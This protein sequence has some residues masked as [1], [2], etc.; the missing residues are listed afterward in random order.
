[1]P[2]DAGTQLG[3]YEILSPIGAGGMGEVYKARDTRLDRT[4]AIKVLPEHVASD[5]DLKQRFEREAKTISSLNHPHICTLYDIGSQDGVDFLVMEYLEG[6]TLAQRLEKGALPLDQALTVAIEIADAL[7]K[8]HRQGITHR[9]LKPGNI[10]LTKAGAKLLDFGLAKLKQA[11]GVPAEFSA[12][13]TQSAGLTAIGTILG[14]LQHMAPEQLAG[15]EADARSDIF[16]LGTVIYEM[17]TGRKAFEG[18]S[19]ATLAGAILHVEPSSMSSIQPMASPALDHLV[20]TCLAKDQDNRWQSAGDLGRQLQMIREGGSQVG[21]PVVT[22]APQAAGWRQALPWMLAALAVGSVITG[23]AVWTATR[24]GPPI[25]RPVARTTL[26]VPPEEPLGLNF[27]NTDVAISPDGTHVVYAGTRDGQPQLFVRALDQLEATAL[28]G[29]GSQ[30]RHP[31]LS[32]DGNWVGF[33]AN[34]VLQRV[35]IRGGPPIPIAEVNGQPR[36]AS[37]GVDDTIVFAT[38]N[39]GTGLWR[40]ASGGGGEPEV[41]TTPDTDRGELNHFWPEIL[42]GGQAVLFTIRSQGS[43]ENAQIAVLSLERGTY[44]VVLPGGSHARYVPT[45]H[46]VYGVRG[47][48]QAVGFDLDRLAVTTDPVPVVDTVNMK[49]SGAANFSVAQNGSLVYVRWAQGAGGAVSLVWVDRDGNEEPL[50]AQPGAYNEPRISPDG[51]R[52]AL[53]VGDDPGNSSDIHIYDLARNNFTQLTFTADGEC[54]PVWMP[55]GERVVF[56]STRDGPPN[57]YVKNAD[58]TG[59]AERLTEGTDPQTPHDVTEDGRTVVFWSQG[60]VHTLSLDRERTASALVQTESDERVLASRPMAGGSPIRPT[61]LA[62]WKCS[63][64]HFPRSKADAGKPR[65]TAATVPCGRLTGGSCSFT[66]VARCGRFRSRPNPASLPS[67]RSPCSRDPTLLNKVP[68]FG[69]STSPPMAS[70]F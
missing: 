31:F 69:P 14:T 55:D 64:A 61:S 25:P 15:E 70:G 42:P 21:V 39:P 3:P 23:L 59:E 16:A 68:R 30:P 27:P 28:T 1:M 57:L 26:T 43:I 45:G 6:D 22:A 13:P 10:M 2:L 48:L 52:V 4:V 36:G 34:R 50:A 35:S 65:L 11:A 66:A 54:C 51:T 19:Q 62:R 24:P 41:L 56:T 5:P 47:T 60:N 7:D 18:T 12:S 46:L 58:G 9:D 67:T 37:W 63:C 33:F 40:V 49:I 44:E 8:A 32:P 38:L 29:L 17:V 53:R 20:R